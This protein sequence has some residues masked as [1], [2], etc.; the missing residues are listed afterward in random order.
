M[1]VRFS[2]AKEKR[3]HAS[4]RL[5]SDCRGN[6]AV[7]F[8]LL[9]PALFALLV[10]GM[11]FGRLMWTLSG[12]HYATEEGARCYAMGICTS[13]SAATQAASVAPEFG[14][15]SANFTVS[16]ATCGYKVV[17]SYAFTWLPNSTIISATAPTLRSTACFP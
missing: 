9:A 6:V 5:L 11:E 3:G 15:T 14:F 2:P 8:A 13:T 16:S 1:M 12:L 4:A 17:G 10:G 7:E